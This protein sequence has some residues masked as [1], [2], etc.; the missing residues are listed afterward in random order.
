MDANILLSALLGRIR[1]LNWM[2]ATSGQMEKNSQ[3]LFI[4]R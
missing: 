3:Q 4:I 1:V 2:Y